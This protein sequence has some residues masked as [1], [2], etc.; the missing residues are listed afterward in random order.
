[1]T[2]VEPIS[3]EHSLEPVKSNR[4]TWDVQGLFLPIILYGYRATPGRGRLEFE[5]SLN[6]LFAAIVKMMVNSSDDAKFVQVR[7]FLLYSYLAVFKCL[8]TAALTNIFPAPP[9]MNLYC[10]EVIR[11][12]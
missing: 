8:F 12:F 5:A 4:P 11:D 6:G 7:A 2:C 9:L 10:V 3:F 1:M